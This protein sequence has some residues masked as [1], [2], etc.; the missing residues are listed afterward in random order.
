MAMSSLCSLVAQVVVSMNRKVFQL[1]TL[2]AAAPSVQKKSSGSSLRDPQVMQTPKGNGAMLKEM[3]LEVLGQ[4]L[5]NHSLVHQ[6][7]CFPRENQELC[8][9]DMDEWVHV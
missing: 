4:G 1:H 2:S 6:L 7:L 3:F 8:G 9:S 5:A